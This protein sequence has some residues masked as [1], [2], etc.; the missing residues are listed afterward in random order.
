MLIQARSQSHQC[1][2][3]AEGTLAEKRSLLYLMGRLFFTSNQPVRAGMGTH[4]ELSPRFFNKS[5]KSRF[6][7]K[8]DITLHVNVEVD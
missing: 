6:K 5:Q 1:V 2:G 4:L 7:K 8:I 3:L